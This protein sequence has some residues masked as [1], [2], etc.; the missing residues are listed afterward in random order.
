MSATV[1][2]RELSLEDRYTAVSG[3]ILLDGM[4]A[5]VRRML[6]LRWLDAKRGHATGV[7][8]SGY[9]GSPL[10][11][12]DLE[13]QRAARQ[14]DAAGIVVHPGLNEELAA[15]AVAATQL[16]GELPG[17]TKQGVTGFWYGKAPGLDRASDAMRHGNLSGTAPLGGA[18]AFVG[19]D[20]MAKAST[21]PA[22]SEKVCRALWMPIPAPATIAELL[23]LGQHAV[24][25]SRHAGVWTA[26][27]IV[28]D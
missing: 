12:L 24:E 15:T 14:L 22:S 20:P 13:L 5:L 10:G 19:D 11:G 4:Q 2:L 26:L 16:L 6:D 21:V 25:I 27:K 1:P 23:E 3:P 8:V 9:P 7:F 18:V 17:A 28:T